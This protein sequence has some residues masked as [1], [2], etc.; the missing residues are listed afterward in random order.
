[1]QQRKDTAQASV[2][3]SPDLECAAFHGEVLLDSIRHRIFAVSLQSSRNQGADSEVS[4]KLVS[5]RCQGSLAFSRSRGLCQSL[6]VLGEQVYFAGI[7]LKGRFG[8]EV[9]FDGGFGREAEDH[10]VCEELP[11]TLRSH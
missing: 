4:A 3:R 6:D 9:L 1:M 10:F 11:C 8:R 5:D 7:S 2:V